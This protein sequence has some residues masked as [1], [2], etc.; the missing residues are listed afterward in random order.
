M[1]SMNCHEL[2]GAC[3]EVFSAETFEEIAQLSQ[4]HGKKMHEAQDAAHLAA[5]DKMRELMQ[6]QDA[7]AAWFEGRRK[8]FDAL[9]ED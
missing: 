4:Q 1:K 9:P 3:D 2:G 5:M 7:M 8:A 6:D